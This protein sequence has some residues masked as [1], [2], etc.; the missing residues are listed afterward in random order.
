[1]GGGPPGAPLRY[2]LAPVFFIYST[3]NPPEISWHS[4][5]FYFCTKTTPW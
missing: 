4:E 5:N 3:K 2:V 1:V